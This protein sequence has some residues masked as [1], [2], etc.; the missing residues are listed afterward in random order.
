M[1]KEEL[2]AGRETWK[3]KREFLLSCIAYAVGLGNIWRFDLKL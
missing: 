1:T 3:N 2:S